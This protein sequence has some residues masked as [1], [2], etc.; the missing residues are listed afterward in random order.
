MS[1]KHSLRNTKSFWIL[2]NN[3][4]DFSL[5]FLFYDVTYRVTSIL[6][7]QTDK[8]LFALLRG[9]FILQGRKH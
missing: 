9:F 7:R 2:I 5:G 8:K 3:T 1:P 6:P 4:A